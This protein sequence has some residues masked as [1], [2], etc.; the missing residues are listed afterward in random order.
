MAEELWRNLAAEQH[1]DVARAFGGAVAEMP[2][3]LVELAWSSPA[4]LAIVPMQDLLG[5]GSEARMNRPGVVDGNWRW[6]FGWD[7]LP[8]DFEATLRAALARHGR[9]A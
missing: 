7:E 1:A 3:A 4:P 2:R 8:D 9:I 5:L 6:S